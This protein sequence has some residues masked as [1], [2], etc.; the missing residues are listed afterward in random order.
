MGNE[1]EH[2]GAR[3]RLTDDLDIALAFER[4][5]DAGKHQGMI[6]RQQNSEFFQP[7]SPI[8][9]TRATGHLSQ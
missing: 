6:I 3:R 9:T 1:R 5:P 8:L 4:P 7:L 2:L